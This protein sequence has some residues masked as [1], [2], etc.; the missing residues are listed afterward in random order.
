MSGTTIRIGDGAKNT[1]TKLTTSN[2]PA[3]SKKGGCGC[4]GRK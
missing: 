2:K 1:A 4:G 3:G